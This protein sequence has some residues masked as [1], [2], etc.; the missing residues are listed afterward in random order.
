MQLQHFNLPPPP[1]IHKQPVN[2]DKPLS[3]IEQEL[4]LPQGYQQQIK[5][6]IQSGIVEIAENGELGYID[7]NDNFQKIPS[8]LEFKKKIS[9]S[10]NISQTNSMNIIMFPALFSVTQLT[11]LYA[12]QASLY[13]KSQPKDFYINDVYGGQYYRSSDHE[14][15]KSNLYNS[16]QAQIERNRINN[17]A[18]IIRTTK[19][20]SI[21]NLS[22]NSWGFIQYKELPIWENPDPKVTIKMQ[23]YLELLE[24]IALSNQ[25]QGRIKLNRDKQ[26]TITEINNQ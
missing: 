8:Y 5:T 1:Q 17:D 3:K 25:T 23:F 14:K 12:L 15:V 11:D 2:Q 26:F 22:N 7:K 18:K 10:K 9:S 13:C 21:D 20:L 4:N 19:W 24:F 6:L 16:L